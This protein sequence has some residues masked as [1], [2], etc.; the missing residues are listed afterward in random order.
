M[1]RLW[2]GTIVLSLVLSGWAATALAAGTPVRVSPRRGG[3]HTNF[4]LRFAIPNA[5]GTAEDLNVSD[6]IT[7]QGPTHAGCV[8]QVE[9]PLH[10]AKA[11]TAFKVT[12][13]PSHLNQSW[14]AGRYSGQLVQRTTTVCRGGPPAQIACPLFVLAPRVLSRFRFTVTAPKSTAP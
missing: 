2:W 10:S 6:Y 9:Q 7:V 3:V 12:L 14:C 5:T 4:V 8:G 1:K 13:N 11:H